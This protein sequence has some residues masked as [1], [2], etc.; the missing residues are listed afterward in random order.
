MSTVDSIRDCLL[1]FIDPYLQFKTV[2]AQVIKNI[3]MQNHDIHI[4]LEFGYPIS[5]RRSKENHNGLIEFLTKAF[6]DSQFSL[7]I[8]WQVK[9]HIIQSGL[10]SLPNIKNIIAV[11]SGKGGVGKSTTAVNMA[12]ALSAQGAAVGLL[13]A[14]IYGPNQP[15]MLGVTET[16]PVKEGRKLAPVKIYGIQSMSIGYLIDP[17]TPMVWRGPMVTSALLQLLNDTAWENLDYLIIDLPPGTGDIQL[18]LAQK[19]PVSGA[20][21]VTTPQ[22]VALQDGRKGIEM[23]QKVKVPIL[24]VVENMSVYICSH[25][26]HSDAIFGKGGGQQLAQEY[27][28]SYLG[29]IPLV[30]R[31]REQSDSG[32]PIVVADPENEISLQ[33]E[34]IAIEIVSKLSLQGRSYAHHFPKITIEND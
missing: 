18:T 33:Y 22:E 29:G 20:V 21:I 6:P 14:D 8:T 15:Q 12:L 25:C 3:R 34:K 23:F 9:P 28:V 2:T 32:C 30:S 5:P 13:D 24:G 19:I 4:Q 26:H 27:N 7:D 10:Q 31:I 17:T 11:A 1:S 16:P